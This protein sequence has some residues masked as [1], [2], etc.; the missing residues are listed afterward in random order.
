MSYKQN[1]TTVYLK[2]QSSAMQRR[3]PC[4]LAPRTTT[5]C[6][7]RSPYRKWISSHSNTTL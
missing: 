2:K 4:A 1:F 7:G 5:Q 6:R 3:K